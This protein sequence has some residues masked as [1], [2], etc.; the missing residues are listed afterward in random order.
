MEYR[1]EKKTK[2][3][4]YKRLKQIARFQ[5]KRPPP[6]P[7]PRAKEI[8][9]EETTNVRDRFSGP[10]LLEIAQRLKEMHSAKTKENFRGGSW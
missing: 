4:A 1:A 9:A 8:Q 5:G 6:N 2:K 7:Y 10:K 3:M